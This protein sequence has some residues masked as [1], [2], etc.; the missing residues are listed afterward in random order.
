MN[1]TLKLIEVGQF[2]LQVLTCQATEFT[3][4]ITPIRKSSDKLRVIGLR[5]PFIIAN[6]CTKVSRVGYIDDDITAYGQKAPLVMNQISKLWYAGTLL[7]EGDSLE[8]SVA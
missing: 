5:F 6:R 4:R 8:L 7:R 1:P 3:D 2:P